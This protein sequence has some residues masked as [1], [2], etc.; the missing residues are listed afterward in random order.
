MRS[1][2]LFNFLIAQTKT[3]GETD[4][5]PIWLTN[6]VWTRLNYIIYF[7]VSLFEFVAN[8]TRYAA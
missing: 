4:R 6:V 7:N 2:T 5:I 1:R 8:V 3:S